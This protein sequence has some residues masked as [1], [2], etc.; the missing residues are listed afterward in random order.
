MS[1]SALC[2]SSMSATIVFS[3]FTLANSEHVKMF[4]AS[5]SM[6][7][8]HCIYKTM[9]QCTSGVVFPAMLHVY[10]PFNDV[11]LS[12]NTMAFMLAKAA[13]PANVSGEPVLLKGIYVIPV[14]SNANTED[15]EHHIPNFPHPMIVA[16]GLLSSQPK[17]LC[18]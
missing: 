4:R 15:Y 2:S 8:Y 12:D 14:P 9:I 13:I 18:D 6:A 7:T 16:L 3:F 1:C 5:L 11:V 17:I 10:S